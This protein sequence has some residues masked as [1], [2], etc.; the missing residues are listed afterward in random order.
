MVS[1][2][3][4]PWKKLVVLSRGLFADEDEV[5]A[6]HVRLRQK[7][8]LQDQQQLYE[9]GDQIPSNKGQTTSPLKRTRRQN[10]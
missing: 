8:H 10:V 5:L 3:H 9:H 7:M 1:H 6:G 2:H 4:Y